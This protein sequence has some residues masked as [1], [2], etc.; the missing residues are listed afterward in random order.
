MAFVG[1]NLRGTDTWAGKAVGMV[2]FGLTF[3]LLQNLLQA[4]PGIARRHRAHLL[5][6][7]QPGGIEAFNP[8]GI[9]RAEYAVFRKALIE[10]PGQ[11]EF[12]WFDRLHRL[13]IHLGQHDRIHNRYHAFAQ[14][15]AAML[16]LPWT[17]VKAQSA[18]LAEKHIVASSYDVL[19]DPFGT[20]FVAIQLDGYLKTPVMVRQIHVIDGKLRLATLLVRILGEGVADRDIP[21][22]LALAGPAFRDPFSGQP[23]QW[24][25]KERRIQFPDQEY[26]GLMY[27]SLRVPAR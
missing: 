6:L 9:V 21:A 22:F 17:D 4:D 12:R 2:S 11:S 13:A 5:A 24:D 7:L 16:R 26:P 27:A 19:I 1:R 15:Y 18:R 14:D 8:D 10:P 25:A 23:A 20:M 3:E